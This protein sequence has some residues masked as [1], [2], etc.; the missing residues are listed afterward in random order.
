MT[1][2]LPVV[3]ILGIGAV[4]AIKYRAAGIGVVAL[5]G[6]FGFYLSDTGAAST[7]NQLM[8]AFGNAIGDIAN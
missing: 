1:V 8:T 2:T 3:L 7:I 4:V 5:A 6:L